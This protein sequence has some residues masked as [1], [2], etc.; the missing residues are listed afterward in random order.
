MHSTNVLPWDDLTGIRV[1]KKF[2]RKCRQ[3]G[4]TNDYHVCDWSAR[5]QIF[6]QLIPYCRPMLDEV[7]HL[8]FLGSHPASARRTITAM[9]TAAKIQNSKDS[10]SRVKVKA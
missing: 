10:F 1:N 7:I 9:R 2:V 5:D 3:S 4:R 6:F 8:S